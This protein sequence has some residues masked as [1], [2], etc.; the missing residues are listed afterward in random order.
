M[1]WTKA[2]SL[3]T[4]FGEMEK[5]YVKQSREMNLETQTTELDLEELDAASRTWEYFGELKERKNGDAKLR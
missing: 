2:S 4:S 1:I 5:L 3:E